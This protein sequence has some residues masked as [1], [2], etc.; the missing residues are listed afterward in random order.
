MPTVLVTGATGHVGRE[1]ALALLASGARIRQV[2]GTC[3]MSRRLGHAGSPP[4]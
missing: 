2:P 1:V 3:P 4:R